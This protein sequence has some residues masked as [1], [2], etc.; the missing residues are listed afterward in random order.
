V[1]GQPWILATR[2]AGK[3]REL[4]ALFA[5]VGLE[6]VD[7]RDAN[8]RREVLRDGLLSGQSPPFCA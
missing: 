5:D 4:R 6:V 1:T 8:R 3:L 7:G 2:N